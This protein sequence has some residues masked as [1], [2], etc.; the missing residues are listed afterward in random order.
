MSS[1][2]DHRGLISEIRSV[3]FR[4]LHCGWWLGVDIASR[5]GVA[6]IRTGNG[7]EA[8][9]EIGSTGTVFQCFNK[10]YN[11]SKGNRDGMRRSIEN[12]R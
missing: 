6:K 9:S 10:L 3:E 7:F 4:D 11:N 12:C 2:P 5:P 1:N 8:C